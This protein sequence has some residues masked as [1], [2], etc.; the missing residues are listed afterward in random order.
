MSADGFTIRNGKR[1]HLKKGE[2]WGHMRGSPG[3]SQAINNAVGNDVSG[4][5]TTQ[6]SSSIPHYC[7]SGVSKR[8]ELRA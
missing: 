6:P 3:A 1:W 5:F 2:A 4:A 7:G 8:A